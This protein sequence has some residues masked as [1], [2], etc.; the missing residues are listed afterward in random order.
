MRKGVKEKLNVDMT[1][2]SDLMYWFPEDSNE[3][4]IQ[5]NIHK[6]RN[7]NCSHYRVYTQIRE[8]IDLLIYKNLFKIIYNIDFTE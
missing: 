5:E 3:I 2:K 7:N 1:N 8:K 4:T 6:A